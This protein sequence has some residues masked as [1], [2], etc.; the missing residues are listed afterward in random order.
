MDNVPKTSFHLRGG[1][2]P[3]PTQTKID[4]VEKKGADEIYFLLRVNCRNKKRQG[5]RGKVNFQQI[6]FPLGVSFYSSDAMLG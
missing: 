4:A 6:L 3:T 5:R 1:E 2:R